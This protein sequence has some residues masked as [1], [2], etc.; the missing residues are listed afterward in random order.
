MHPAGTESRGVPGPRNFRTRRGP[1]AGAKAHP[2]LQLPS[3]G[4]SAAQQQSPRDAA[5]SP[6]DSV[7][8]L[9]ETPLE[10]PNDTYL[11]EVAAE[12]SRHS[13]GVSVRD[14]TYHFTKY[15]KC[16]VGA[17][18]V[19]W[20]VA[21]EFADDTEAAVALGQELLSKGHLEHVHN[22]QRFL[23]RNS[24]F[25]RF[26]VRRRRRRRHTTSQT[27]LNVRLASAL[28]L[29]QRLET[30]EAM[31]DDL[32]EGVVYLTTDNE[33]M[34][35]CIVSLEAASRDQMAAAKRSMLAH[36][37]VLAVSAV[38]YVLLV[39]AAGLAW[40]AALGTVCAV[41]APSLYWSAN[42][43]DRAATVARRSS[44]AAQ[45][46]LERTR[47][48]HRPSLGVNLDVS[49]R[50]DSSESSATQD[51]R[52]RTYDSSSSSS[53]DDGDTGS[54]SDSG[55]PPTATPKL[56]S[57]NTGSSDTLERFSSA[58]SSF[59]AGNASSSSSA[60]KVM[61]R[62]SLRRGSDTMP[63][64]HQ[65]W[66]LPPPELFTVRGATYLEDA[67]KVPGTQPLFEL[68]RV[69]FAAIDTAEHLSNIAAQPGTPVDLGLR[70][71][72]DNS[73]ESDDD[74]LGVRILE[75]PRGGGGGDLGT[76][77]SFEPKY[78][79]AQVAAVAA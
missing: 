40:S 4:G 66:S 67:V 61:A 45:G 50:N 18:G 25:Y 16:F 21:N 10:S 9:P 29:K 69:D 30:T 28:E 19:E 1:M 11:R 22:E 48:M 63:D 51:L 27:T 56:G 32:C 23:N 73:S 31:V 54:D 12:M 58:E 52:S 44:E 20:L 24:A 2:Q 39:E 78:F 15:R 35:D 13:T 43:L 14:R 60:A 77:E 71:P 75:R 17:R 7:A 46:S 36:I 8:M 5:G 26:T 65:C 42:R 37:A 3:R 34:R 62:R 47:S 59:Q 33:S 49:R 76:A 70:A 6:R 68:L 38:G 72:N 53:D 64:Q 79:G 55:A 74:S 57:S 41:A